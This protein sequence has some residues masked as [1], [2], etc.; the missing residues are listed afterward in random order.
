MHPTMAALLGVRTGER[1]TVETRRG[2]VTLKANV[3]ETIRDDTIFIPYHWA[4]KQSANKL[5]IRALDP[6]SKIP[7]F[8][9]CA[10]RV[11]RAEQQETIDG[12][13]GGRVTIGTEP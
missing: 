11:T 6:V 4:D 8:K 13:V 1:V 7:E 2:S 10:C 3:V 9:V 5:T 12:V